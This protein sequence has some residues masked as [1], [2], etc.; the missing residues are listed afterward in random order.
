MKVICDNCRA[1]YKI[2]DEKLVK[3]VNKATCRQCGHRMLIPRPRVDA[4]PDERTLVTAV[5]PT[6]APPPPRSE[7]NDDPPTNPLG[8][9]PEQTVPHGADVEIHTATPAPVK[10]QRKIQNQSRQTESTQPTRPARIPAG[11]AAGTHDPAG[12]MSIAF[13]GVVVAFIGAVFL[14]VVPLLPLPDYIGPFT[15]AIGLMIAS[16]GSLLATLVM[17]TGARGRKPAKPLLSFFIAGA[18]AFLL[19]L[20]PMLAGSLSNTSALSSGTQTARIEIPPEQTVASSDEVA[21]DEATPSEKVE[22]APPAKK[23]AKPSTAKTDTKKDTASSSSSQRSRNSSSSRSDSSS[24]RDAAVAPYEPPEP[25]PTRR[26]EPQDID[27]LELP[28]DILLDEP[29]E[30]A[31][32]TSSGRATPPATTRP[33]GSSASSVDSSLP[34]RP[35]VSAIDVMVKSNAN[36]K[37]CFIKE[38][39]SKGTIPPRIDLKF[40]I[41][42]DGSATRVGIKQVEYAATDLDFCLG[43]A[44]K[45]IRFPPSQKG[46]TLTF[47]LEVG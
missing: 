10:S 31:R 7:F 8:R 16:G 22:D 12:D 2:P 41:R 11:A 17:L 26:S 28:D 13:M 21:K 23:P 44:I 27:E 24:R 3:P 34:E 46:Q 20:I 29:D 40:T 42:P 18:L 36:V 37:R 4:D 6:P 32:P 15:S 19:G 35:S 38:Q 5:P 45:S 30:P 33:S 14:S 1:V 39:A 43:S 9:N 47:P 25:E